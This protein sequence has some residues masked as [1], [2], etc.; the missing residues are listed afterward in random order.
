MTHLSLKKAI[1][2]CKLCDI[3][4]SYKGYLPATIH[5]YDLAMLL[6]QTVENS[7]KTDHESIRK[8]LESIETY[9]GLM[10]S[11]TK[12]FSSDKHD[13][14]RESDYFLKQMSFN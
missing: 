4:S 5:A 12:P 7:G 10:G 8:G 9:D 14:L 11:F 3:D 2:D 13:A 6:F 1:N